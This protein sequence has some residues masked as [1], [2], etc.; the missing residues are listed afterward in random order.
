[1]GIPARGDGGEQRRYFRE[2]PDVSVTPVDF[3]CSTKE[4]DLFLAWNVT[5]IQG[6]WKSRACAREFAAMKEA[7]RLLQAAWR[8]HRNARRIRRKRGRSRNSLHAAAWRIQRCWHSYANRKVF[9]YYK[10]LITNTEKLHPS[11]LL[12]RINPSEAALADSATGLHIRFRLG[13]ITF[14]PLLLYKLYTHRPVV[15]MGSFSP[16]KYSVSL[17][18]PLTRGRDPRR[19]FQQPVKQTTE[20]YVRCENNGWRL[21]CDTAWMHN[22]DELIHDKMKIFYPSVTARREHK[23]QE[24]RKKKRAWL[25]KLYKEGRLAEIAGTAPS[26]NSGSVEDDNRAIEL[27]LWSL[28][29]NFDS[30]EAH[31]SNLATSCV[32]PSYEFHDGQPCCI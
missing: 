3:L 20:E 5:K 31:W 1:M 27:F 23:A 24:S 6:W 10:D 21:V 16:R 28:G 4:S 29:L 22:A 7:A 8:K 19:C 9:R 14:P 18:R 25:N 11:L 32:I 12:R 2:T 30:Y 13:G 15:D 26:G 17:R